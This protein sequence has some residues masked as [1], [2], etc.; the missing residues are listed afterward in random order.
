[1]WGMQLAGVAGK[2]VVVARGSAEKMEE[3]M[4]EG[5]MVLWK[6]IS[7][8][9]LTGRNKKFAKMMGSRKVP[10]KSDG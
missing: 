10:W 4:K 2:G 5:A 7:T 6:S 1:M 3:R 8:N 9:G